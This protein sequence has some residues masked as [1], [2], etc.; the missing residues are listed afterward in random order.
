MHR[1]K[2]TRVHEMQSTDMTDATKKKWKKKTRQLIIT[3]TLTMTTTNTFRQISLTRVDCNN[4]IP[5]DRF[6]VAVAVAC[7]SC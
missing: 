2:Q 1:K 4:C 3:N 5:T 6:A 7:N